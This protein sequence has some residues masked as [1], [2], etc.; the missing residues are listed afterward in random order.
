ML[1]ASLSAF[2][3]HGT[4]LRVDVRKQPLLAQFSLKE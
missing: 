4:L 1:A 3:L 2:A